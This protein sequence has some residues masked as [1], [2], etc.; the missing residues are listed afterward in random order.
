MDLIRHFKQNLVFQ[1]MFH[2][3]LKE[4]SPYRNL[5]AIASN[6]T[7]K[8]ESDCSRISQENSVVLVSSILSIESWIKVCIEK[9]GHVDEDCYEVNID[10]HGIKDDTI[11]ADRVLNKVRD[12][13]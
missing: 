12:T 9:V 2:D 6:M 5:K 4:K 7:F 13:S 1:C 11:L 3:A 8:P 10:I